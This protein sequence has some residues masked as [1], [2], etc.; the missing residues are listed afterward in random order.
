MIGLTGWFPRS[1]NPV[2][3]GDY[4]CEIAFGRVRGITK[5]YWDGSRWGGIVHV[6]AWRGLAQP[7]ALG[8]SNE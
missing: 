2:H 7:N 1:V 8:A 5:C 4:E 3:A 6:V